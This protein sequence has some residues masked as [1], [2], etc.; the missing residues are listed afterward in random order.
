M[1]SA[2]C[3]NLLEDSPPRKGGIEMPGVRHQES[4][5]RRHAFAERFGPPW[6]D[7]LESGVR[8]QD[9]CLET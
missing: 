6:S 1:A 2:E 4:G 3:G 8:S 7:G 9:L 5:I